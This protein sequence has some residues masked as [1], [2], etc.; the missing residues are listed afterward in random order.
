[1]AEDKRPELKIVADSAPEDIFNDLDA[2]R[3]TATLK[4]SRRA[5]PVNVAVRK[6]ADNI[7]FRCH[8]DPTMHLEASLLIDKEERDAYFVAPVMLNH[9]AVLSRLRRVTIATTYAWPGGAIFLWPV[10]FVDEGRR[11]HATWKSAR[12][13]FELSIDQWVQI[14][15]NAETRDYDVAVAEHIKTEPMWP[16]DLNLRNLLK[17]GFADKT[18]DSPEH[19]YVKQL[20]G[21]TD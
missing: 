21:L 16:D 10:P 3:K 4:V 1:M 13:A 12:R 18:V 7:Y 8:H 15:W 9:P 19:Y 5:V 14:C 17:L 20:R 2:L 6:P 11:V